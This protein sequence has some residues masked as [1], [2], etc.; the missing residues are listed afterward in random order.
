MKDKKK[1]KRRTYLDIG[2]REKAKDYKD[3]RTK[4]GER[5]QENIVEKKSKLNNFEREIKSTDKKGELSL[6][7]KQIEKHRAKEERT[8]DSNNLEKITTE[9]RQVKEVIIEEKNLDIG[10]RVKTSNYLGKRVHEKDRFDESIIKKKTKLKHSQ[11]KT[12]V[13]KNEIAEDKE[14]IVGGDRNLLDSL[15]DKSINKNKRKTNKYGTPDKETKSNDSLKEDAENPNISGKDDEEIKADAYEETSYDL[16]VLNK[17]GK[18]SNK[19]YYKR[20]AIYASQ[21]KTNKRKD[22]KLTT[23]DVKGL[24]DGM[25]N[26]TD[27]K[28]LKENITLSEKSEKKYRKTESRLIHKGKKASKLYHKSKY[29]KT[30]KLLGGISGASYLTSEYMRAGSDEN[31]AIDAANKGLYLNANMTRHAQNRLQRKR[32]SPLKVERKLDLNHKKN[33]AKAE[34]NTEV[35]A[36]KKD[37]NFQKKSAYKKLIKRKQMKKKIYEEHNIAVTFKD[38]L[39]RGIENILKGSSQVIRRNIRRLLILLAVAIIGFMTLSQIATFFI[40][41]ISSVTS[42]VMSTT[43]LSGE[44]TL[45]DINSEFTN[46]EYELAD[47]L[48]NIESYY[49]GYD[50]YHVGGNTDIGHGIHELLS[51]ITA[52]HGEVTNVSSLSGE[53]K[54]L[55]NNMY[56]VNYETI[57][58]TRYRQVCYGSGEDRYCVMEPYDWHVLKVTVT[59]KEMDTVAREEFDGYEENLAHYEALLETGGNME[60]YFGGSGITPVIPDSTIIGELVNNPN[61]SDKEKALVLAAYR[62]PTAGGGYCAAW[63]SNVYVNA[64]YPRPGGNANDQYYWYCNSNDLSELRPGMMVAVPTHNHT[65]AGKKYGHVGIYVGNGVIRENIG[66]VKDTKLSD[67]IAYY[68]SSAKWGFPY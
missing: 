55:F 17:N 32:K 47:E 12:S 11:V 64:G 43:Y 27:E 38:R 53:L 63:V 45:A 50:E 3:K 18:V 2:K 20:K 46:Y 10:A 59:K 25:D 16:E 58:E 30:G 51:F 31:V 44:E 24:K 19:N 9:S 28:S 22:G 49:P 36:L 29:S 66:I 61:L 40:G 56:K 8:G 48:A 37:Q 62:T 35:E 21:K 5:F 7:Q 15:N 23:D 39:K 14:D 26:R 60:E 34:Y 67:W 57:V 52:K 33:M 4:D 65:Q 6:S 54:N 68:G 13:K 1:I 41:G 42:Q